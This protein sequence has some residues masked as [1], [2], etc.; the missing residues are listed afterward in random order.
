MQ[1]VLDAALGWSCLNHHFD[2]AAF[3]LEHGADIDTRWSTH[4]P[5]SILHEAAVRG[6]ME[7]AAFLID[8][9]IDLSIRDHRYHATAEGWARHAARDERMTTFLAEAAARRAIRE[10]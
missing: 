1:N 6:D 9:G 2:V 7:A 5:A 10:P 8:R 4:E 3:L